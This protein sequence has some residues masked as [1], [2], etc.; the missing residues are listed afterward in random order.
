[1]IFLEQVYQ[2]IFSY[3]K[4][5]ILYYSESLGLDDSPPMPCTWPHLWVMVSLRLRQKSQAIIYCTINNINDTGS[6]FCENVN[7]L[8]YTLLCVIEH[9]TLMSSILL[10]FLHIFRN[11]EQSV[12]QIRLT[13]IGAPLPK[14]IHI[15]L[16][17][18]CS[19]S[20]FLAVVIS[21]IQKVS[22]IES[23]MPVC[24]SVQSI[25]TLLLCL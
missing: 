16:I 14:S 22:H 23:K 17:Q 2:A 5:Q 25:V 3:C 19:H 12:L 15:I 11:Q 6:T 24:L 18:V 9:Q 7:Y 21:S 8:T 4:L 1:M 10:L 13:N 20:A